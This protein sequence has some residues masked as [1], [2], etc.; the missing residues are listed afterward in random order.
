[1]GTNN[2]VTS[3]KCFEIL[4]HFKHLREGGNKRCLDQFHSPL[5]KY[6]GT[7]KYEIYISDSPSFIPS[8]VF[9]VAHYS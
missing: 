8:S 7:A 3:T 2:T 1:M 4:T 9:F 5:P 6:T